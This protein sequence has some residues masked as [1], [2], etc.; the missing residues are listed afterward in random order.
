[1]NIWIRLRL[2]DLGLNPVVARGFIFPRTSRQGSGVLTAA[3]LVITGSYFLKV[4]RLGFVANH[5]SQSSA[6]V[7]NIGV[8]HP[9]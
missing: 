5:S 3:Y 2:D 7:K 8:I 4:K 9:G 1:V 6:E